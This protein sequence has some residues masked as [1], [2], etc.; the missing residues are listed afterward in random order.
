MLQQ[1][2]RLNS[3]VYIALGTNTG[4]FLVIYNET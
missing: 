3:V 2:Y 1:L 4:L